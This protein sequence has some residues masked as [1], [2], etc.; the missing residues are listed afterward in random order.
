MDGAEFLTAVA[1]KWPETERILLTGFSDMESTIAAINKGKI[2]YYLEKPWDDDRLRKIINKGIE[3]AEIKHRNALLEK[4]IH[5]QNEKLKVWN[6]RL[7]EQVSERTVE[8]KLSNERLQ[9]S[10][11]KLNNHYQTTIHLFSSLIEQRLG[12]N[13]TNSR[14]FVWAL[15]KLAQR[16]GLPERQH[17][18]L[19]YAGILR[20]IGKIGL[21][22]ELL[23][24]PYL[25]LT[26]IQQREFQR[27]TIIAETLLSSTPPLLE[28]ANILSQREEHEDGSGHPNALSGKNITMPASIL[29]LVSDYFTSCNGYITETPLT[30]SQA[31]TRVKELSGQYYREEVVNAFEKI[32]PELSDRYQIQS[33]EQYSSK[34]LKAGMV[35]SRDLKT[36][37]GTLLLA[38][39]KS[40]DSAII[41]RLIKLE[42]NF[43]EKLNIYVLN[44]ND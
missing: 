21:P 40:L 42:N 2:N 5:E 18:A 26:P 14:T 38:E 17:K 11:S 15:K 3:L 33:E 36:E 41:G 24:T 34:R 4:Q 9:A 13:Q 8:L 23:T 27:H 30:P 35:L 7:E 22:D 20:N 32:W 28:S 43:Q 19:A 25:S 44:E 1:T 10:I 31:L 37:N 12:S 29:C 6:E 16:L 39:G